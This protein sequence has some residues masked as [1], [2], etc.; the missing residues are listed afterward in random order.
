MKSDIFA[1]TCV[2]ARTILLGPVTC[3]APPLKVVALPLLLAVGVAV[4]VI[5]AV[6]P[7]CR[8]GIRQV[9]LVVVAPLPL[10]VPE[11][12]LAVTLLS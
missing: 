7:A 10:H 4:M 1:E 5:V 8:D 6:E 2:E 3:T 11:V 9:T 12:T